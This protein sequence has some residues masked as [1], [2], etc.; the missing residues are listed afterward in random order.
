MYL[1]MLY[2]IIFGLMI[3]KQVDREGEQ[4]ENNNIFNIMYRVVT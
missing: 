2:I 3:T 1:C 4:H